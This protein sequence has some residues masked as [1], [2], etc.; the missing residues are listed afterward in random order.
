MTPATFP[1]LLA[2]GLFLAAGQVAAKPGAYA[3]PSTYDAAIRTA[4]ARWLPWD[5]RWWK[6]QLYA[7]SALDPSAVSPA[8]ARGLAQ[9]MP[10][11]S[12]EV[13]AA[14]KAGAASPHDVAF[15]IEAGAFYMARMRK[16]WHAERP[17]AERRRLAQASYNAGLGNILKAQRACKAA[18]GDPCLAWEEVG[19]HLPSVTG[20]HA[21]ETLGYV[22]RIERIHA[23]LAGL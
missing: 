17:E 14:L 10:G 19:A 3:I 12:R 23:R 13:A 18:T 7:E 9:L 8:G 6:A 11:T 15:A 22:Q 5:Y 1:M 20:R 2:F 16:A 21:K 4:S